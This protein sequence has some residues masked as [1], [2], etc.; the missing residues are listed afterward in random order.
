MMVLSIDRNSWHCAERL[1]S[2][3]EEKGLPISKYKK[4]SEY[5]IILE[6]IKEFFAITWIQ[7]YDEC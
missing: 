3:Y 5:S 2:I 6:D 1:Y 4:L 7:I